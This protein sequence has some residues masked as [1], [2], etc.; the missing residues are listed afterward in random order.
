MSETSRV[1]PSA[2]VFPAGQVTMTSSRGNG[3]EL[4][5][6]KRHLG[7]VR[8]ARLHMQEHVYG[9]MLRIRLLRVMK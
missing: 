9:G 5:G 4:P 7:L 8:G 2:N 6:S 3:G 1:N